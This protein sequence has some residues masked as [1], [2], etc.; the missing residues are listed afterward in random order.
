M[1][2]LSPGYGL[3][4]GTQRWT[5]QITALELRLVS[6]PEVEELTVVLPA[7]APVKAEPGDAVVLELDG[8]EGARPVFAGKL[9]SVERGLRDIVLRAE[10]A[11]GEMARFFPATTF[12]NV[13]AGTVIR[14]LAADAGLAAGSVTD[15]VQLPFYAADPA[16]SANDHATRLAAW[17]GAL[18]L[19]SPEGEVEATIVDAGNA[20]LALR[21]GRELTG[22]TVARARAADAFTVAGESGAGDV[23]APDALRL[24]TDVFAGNRPSG[25]DL[26]S[27]WSWEPAL[28]TAKAAA[29]A[30]ASRSRDLAALERTAR[31]DAFLLPALRPGLAIE[32]QDLP[33]GMHGGPWWVERVRHRIGP[34]GA[35]T[36]ARLMQGGDPFDPLALL[37]SLVGALGA[38]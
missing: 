36:Q 28:R 11:L 24:S 1:T 14:A 32:I 34:E 15:G 20:T 35:V 9:V 5:Q 6:G 25:P 18:L 13:A 26:G 31:L 19:S 27:L 3:T 16:L 29:S 37:G 30:T 8:G 38:L 4:A 22:F 17:S 12:E 21:Y 7:A 23:G 10:S 33:E 2:I